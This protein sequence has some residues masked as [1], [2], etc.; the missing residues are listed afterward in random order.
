M[1]SRIDTA[2]STTGESANKNQHE[3][4]ITPRLQLVAWEITRTCNLFCAHCRASASDA[5]Y[6]GELTTEECF[7]VIEEIL[8]VGKPIIILTGGEP[9]V[10]QDIF[11]IAKY[12]VNRGL[13]VVVGSNGTLITRE[14]ADK[15]KQI[16]ISRIAISVDFPLADLQNEFRGQVGAYEAA[17]IGIGNLGQAGIDVQINSTITKM[18]IPYLDELLSLVL[19]VGAVAFHPFMLVAAG[20][21]KDLTSEEL[22]PEKYEEV[23]TWIY[24]RQMEM[25]DKVSIRPTDVPHFQRVIKQRQKGQATPVIEKT[26]Q[27]TSHH[28]ANH[29]VR[30]CLAGTGFSF[31]SHRGRVQG[32]GYLDV[33]AGDLRKNSFSKIWADSSLFDHLRDLSNLKGKC[34]LCEYKRICGGCRARAFEAT[35]DC[36]EAEPYCIYQP[37]R[38]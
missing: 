35:G 21:G 27:T 33:E 31:I 23:L 18:N 32:C 20:R 28:P 14:M 16:P 38:Q 10:R 9:L 30:G 5:Q 3:N 22:S 26:N 12:A 25:G 2:S 1:K 11:Q 13:R 4:I 8:E 19:R 36:F 29:V 37:V 24:D 34:G 15:L 6:S 7:Q 17:M